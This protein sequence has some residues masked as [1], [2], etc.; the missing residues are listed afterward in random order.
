L[1]M[2]TGSLALLL[3]SLSRAWNN[4]AP[5]SAVFLCPWGVAC[6]VC[7]CC[8]TKQ[9]RARTERGFVWQGRCVA[10]RAVSPYK[11][12]VWDLEESQDAHKWTATR[13]HIAFL[14]VRRE[15]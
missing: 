2:W 7:S 12:R 15:L 1:N 5:K 14:G 9:E 13:N 6:A 4:R 8:S 3:P 10:G 11:G